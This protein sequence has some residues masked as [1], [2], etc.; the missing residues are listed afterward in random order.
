MSAILSLQQLSKIEQSKTYGYA[1]DLTLNIA[2]C[3]QFKVRDQNLILGSGL[4]L[5]RKANLFPGDLCIDN[6]GPY[7]YS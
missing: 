5:K 2:I 3:W 1:Q 4:T 7:Q 6:K